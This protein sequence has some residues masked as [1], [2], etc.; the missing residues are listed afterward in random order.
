MQDMMKKEFEGGKI[1]DHDIESANTMIT[2]Y[3][4]YLGGDESMAEDILGLIHD[5]IHSLTIWDG[6]KIMRLIDDYIDR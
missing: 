5:D 1:W 4:R 2:D 6:E 3:I